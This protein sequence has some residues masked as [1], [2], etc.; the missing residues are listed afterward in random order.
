MTS[1]AEAHEAPRDRL[2]FAGDRDKLNHRCSQARDRIRLIGR[3]S[4]EGR[5]CRGVMV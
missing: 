2:R 4:R 3:M 5:F 1:V